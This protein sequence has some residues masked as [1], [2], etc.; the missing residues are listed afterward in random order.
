MSSEYQGAAHALYLKVS[1]KKSTDLPRGEAECLL[2]HPAI[3]GDVTISRNAGSHQY[4]IRNRFHD[5]SVNPEDY[6][7]GPDLKWALS[8]GPT[9]SVPLKNGT[10][11]KSV[12]VSRVIKYIGACVE[13]GCE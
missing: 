6:E 13:Y 8:A 2:E 7:L 12:Y 11:V 1:R 9:L 5:L 3:A 4:L 10:Q